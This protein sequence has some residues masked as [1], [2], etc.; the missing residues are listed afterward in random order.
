MEHFKERQ[1]EEQQELERKLMN[2]LK[3]DNAR[4]CER[5]LFAVLGTEKYELIH[6]LVKNKNIIYYGTRYYQAQDEK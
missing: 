1:A 4:D 2:I 5:K 3:A 6:L